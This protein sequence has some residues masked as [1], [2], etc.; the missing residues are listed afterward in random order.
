MVW[1]ALEQTD[2]MWQDHDK[3]DVILT[4]RYLNELTHS[5]WEP[6]KKKERGRLKRRETY[7]RWSS[8]FFGVDGEM[9]DANP[10]C[11]EIDVGLNSG[12]WSWRRNFLRNKN[13]ISIKGEGGWRE[14]V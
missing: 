7:V 3:L 13:V 1:R 6:F 14:E 4:Q 12:E 10:Q 9:T 5:S 11:N 8:V 2:W